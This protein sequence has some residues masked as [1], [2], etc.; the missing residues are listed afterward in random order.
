MQPVYLFKQDLERFENKL[1]KDINRILK[2][3]GLV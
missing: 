1:N 2:E 3:E